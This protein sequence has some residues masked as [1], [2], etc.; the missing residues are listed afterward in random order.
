PSPL[1]RLADHSFAGCALGWNSTSAEGA[2]TFFLSLVNQPFIVLQPTSAVMH[3]STA[4]TRWTV[5][6]RARFALELGDATIIRTVPR[7]RPACRR[8]R[9]V[10]IPAARDAARQCPFSSAPAHRSRALS[11]HRRART[12]HHPALPASSPSRSPPTAVSPCPRCPRPP[13]VVPDAG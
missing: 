1:P 3:S 10:S 4:E 7:Y 8:L 11:R 5:W 12:G 9:S 2:A 13:V 6:P